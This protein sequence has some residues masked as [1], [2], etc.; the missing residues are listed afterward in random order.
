M[1]NQNIWNNDAVMVIFRDAAS[2]LQAIGMH[3]M[4]SSMNLPQGTAVSLHAGVTAEASTAAVIAS[5]CSGESVHAA[6]THNQFAQKLEIAIADAADV[7][8][9]IPEFA[10]NSK[11]SNVER[12]ICIFS[13]AGV[14]ALL[15]LGLPPVMKWLHFALISH[16]YISP[17]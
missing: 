4:V 11:D 7:E 6:D 5:E 14:G 2:R 17:P 8:A 12:F 1:S 15:W 16:G 10:H 13:L 9:T 3:C